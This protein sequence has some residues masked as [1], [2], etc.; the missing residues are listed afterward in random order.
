MSVCLPP[1]PNPL[2]RSMTQ[3]SWNEDLQRTDVKSGPFSA[4]ESEAAKNAARNYAQVRTSEEEEGEE[5]GGRG[6]EGRGRRGGRGGRGGRREE[7][8]G[9]REEGGERGGRWATGAG[10]KEEQVGW[11]GGGEQWRADGA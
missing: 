3:L 9:R 6:G 2:L 7:A 5:G 4:A 10:G 11:G 8:G 1:H